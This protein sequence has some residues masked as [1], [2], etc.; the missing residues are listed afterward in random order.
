MVSDSARHRMIEVNQITDEPDFVQPHPLF[1][2]WAF[3]ARLDTD[4]IRITLAIL[5]GQNVHPRAR[6]VKESKDDYIFFLN[7]EVELYMQDRN[8]LWESWPLHWKTD[9]PLATDLLHAYSFSLDPLRERMRQ[10]VASRGSDL[11]ATPAHVKACLAPKLFFILFH[12]FK[13]RAAVTA[14]GVVSVP[15][16]C[17]RHLDFLLRPSPGDLATDQ[18]GDHPFFGHDMSCTRWHTQAFDA[19]NASDPHPVT[20]EPI[21][22]ALM[23]RVLGHVT[24][25]FSLKSNQLFIQCCWGGMH[26]RASG[27]GAGLLNDGDWISETNML[28]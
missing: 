24:V 22:R 5:R 11:R 8:R 18:L 19:D 7:G 3:H 27:A 23:W 16:V 6:K 26:K 12:D 21:F 20:S 13:D 15:F 2:S 4:H 28:G 10:L 1:F 9:T 17:A 25:K 14:A